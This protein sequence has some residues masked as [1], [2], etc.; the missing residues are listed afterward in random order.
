L[1]PETPTNDLPATSSREGVW[2]S[3]PWLWAGVAGIIGWIAI[4]YWPAFRGEFIWD[5]TIL[6]KRNPLVTGELTFST[7]WFHTD[8][9]LTIVTLWLQW[10]S[11]GDHAAGYHILNV[12]FHAVATLLLW[13]SLS[14]LIR[15]RPDGGNNPGAIAVMGPWTG[16]VLFAIHPV[17]AA[18]VGWISEQKNTLSLIFY[19]GSLS[20]F[21]GWRQDVPSPKR[22]RYAL[23]LFLFL[24]ALLSKSSTVMLP[25]TILLLVWWLSVRISRRII[26]AVAP[27]YLLSLTFGL[28][29]IWF[30]HHQTMTAGAIP[31]ES[32][33]AKIVMASMAAWFYL[34]KALLPLSLSMIYPMWHVPGRSPLEYIP[35]VALAIGLFSLWKF[36]ASRCAKSVLVVALVFL[37]NLLPALGLVDMYYLSISRVS[38]H[39]QYLSLSFLMGA[40]GFTLFLP[41]WR[42]FGLVVFCV[43]AVLFSI[44][45]FQR[46]GMLAKDETL[47]VDTLRHNPDSW[48][49]HNNLGCIRAEQGQI[50]DAMT[51]FYASLKLNAQNAATHANL[52]RALAL[53]KNFAGAEKQLTE[54]VALKP[55]D[56]EMHQ[57]FAQILLEEGKND[58]ALEHLR[59]AVAKTPTAESLSLMGRIFQMNRDIRTAEEHYRLALQK[60][61]KA[62]EALNNLAWLL[63]TSLDSNLRNGAEAV[64]CAEE[65]CRL[66][67]FQNA[68]SMGTLAA[69]YAEAG[70]FTE[71]AETA[72]KA[73]DLA[74]AN[75]D[76]NFAAV[77]R[78]LLRLYQSG[79]PFHQ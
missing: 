28:M 68:Q 38:D 43:V 7:V 48:T 45:T 20:A 12:L 17:A 54:A 70:R 69:A 1:N 72:R 77:N 41:R 56:A 63:A 23:S 26:I 60:N 9:P 39:F 47:W 51:H 8:F 78:Q 46:V 22:W 21:I 18:S 65:A 79:K 29:T 52:G 74:G 27:F 31:H 16:A 2:W 61:P 58:R 30:Q 11:F 15:S 36:R 53:Q 73:A 3:Q 32:W 64:N 76:K 44:R 14:Q 13:R 62:L 5:D 37:L 75:G 34:G 24:L 19:L 25:L 35:L 67:H 49:G 42:G 57:I 10:L 4:V 50:D 33:S 40:I 6:V 66:T 59:T 55:A 71:A